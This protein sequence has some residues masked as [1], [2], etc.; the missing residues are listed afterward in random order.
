MRNLIVFSFLLVHSVF[1]PKA[2]KAQQDISVVIPTANSF[3]SPAPYSPTGD[4]SSLLSFTRE[5]LV[6]LD[7]RAERL[8][9]WLASSV[10]TN[11]AGKTWQFSLR[12]G[13]EWSDGE[14]LDT[15]DIEFTF[16]QILTANGFAAPIAVELR[17][18]VASV[19]IIDDLDF[20]VT[21]RSADI[22]FPHQFLTA[23]REGTFYLLPEH[24]WSGNIAT[25]SSTP[26][27]SGFL[28]PLLGSGAYVADSITATEATFIL[29]EDWWGTKTGVRELPKPEQV[30]VRLF[31]TDDEMIEAIKADEIDFG[32]EV[33]VETYQEILLEN[34]NIVTWN[35]V[36]PISWPSQCPRQLDF[37]TIV[38]PWSDATLRKAAAHFVDQLKIVSEV[39]EGQNYPSP[40]MFSAQP[41]LDPYIQ[42]VIDANYSMSASADPA[43]GN[44]L[45]SE[46]GFSKGPDDIYE[47]DGE[48]LTLT[49]HVANE[50]IQDKAVAIAIADMLTE[51]GIQ[52]AVEAVPGDELW[53]WI[54]PPGDFEAVY[55][56]LSC[57][58]MT[59]PFASMQRYHPDYAVDLGVRSPGYQNMARWNTDRAVEYGQLVDQIEI[60]PL[61]DPAITDLAVEAYGHLAAEMPFVPIV[62]NPKIIPFSTSRWTGWPSGSNPYA[63]PKL[64]WGQ[65]HRIIHQLEQVDN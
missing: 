49:I 24:V 56:W 13:I 8:V 9:P 17:A 31:A 42:A 43:L 61:G 16:D 35:E 50:P 44:V 1:F 63:L 15:E 59:D 4:A 33:D 23:R 12:P 32:P 65:F 10:E 6:L 60:L 41:G 45:L 20:V 21:L 29:N 5:P 2:L 11:D 39:F 58:S 18:R 48:D 27:G 40:T 51:A 37:N 36:T 46:A 25:F 28:E 22:R 30:V 3:V 34:S 62:Q 26:L 64:E 47:K 7:S 14:V 19:T 54:M 55:S 53:A 57:A 52:T 38:A